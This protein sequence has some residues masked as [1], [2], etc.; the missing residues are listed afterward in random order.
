MAPTEQEIP[1]KAANEVAHE[2]ADKA[3]DKAAEVVD[4]DAEAP[5]LKPI[6]DP[7]SIDFVRVKLTTTEFVSVY[8]GMAMAILL[9]SLDQT[10]VSTA[11]PAIIKDFQA[12]DRIAWI[13]TGYLLTSTSF[14]PLYGKFADIFGRKSSF[15]FAIIVFLVGS[16]ICGIAPSMDWLIVGRA[17]AGVGGGGIFSLVIIIISDIVSFRDRGKYQGII[18]AV[19]GLSSVI[20]PL[21]GGAFTDN[22]SWRWCFFINIPVGIITIIV[23]VF[24]LKF[25]P[26]EGSIASKIKRIDFLG[27]FVIISAVIALL[28]P[29]QYGG[30]KWEW[31]DAKTIGCLC[32]SA[33]LFI[34]F[35]FVELKVAAEPVVPGS[36]FENVSVYMFLLISFFI[37]GAFIGLIYYLPSYFQSVNGDSATQAGLETIPLVGG[38]VLLSILSGQLVSRYGYYVPFLYFGSVV[39][40]LGIALCST[41]NQYTTRAQQVGYLIIA[42]C[43]LGS[44]LQIRVIGIQM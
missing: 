12:L 18:G 3:A 10:I 25:P 27:T 38:V 33:A 5:K 4:V 36:L 21:V 20:G 17:I 30:D 14:A 19:F 11:I 15:L 44:M 34:A 42:G 24:L 29:L 40:T 37:G 28:I 6:D 1:A 9:A 22:L 43:G 35:I 16:V 23:I 41:F 32:L 8:F 39:L 2:T 26:T 13:G 31:T 7:T